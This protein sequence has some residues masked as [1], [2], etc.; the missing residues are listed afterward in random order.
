MT[1]RH[2]ETILRHCTVSFWPL[3]SR[4]SQDVLGFLGEIP[5][6]L[7]LSRDGRGVYLCNTRVASVNPEV[8]TNLFLD[9]RET[10]FFFVIFGTNLQ[11]REREKE[12]ERERREE[13]R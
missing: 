2:R 3:S 11:T 9:R 12:R 4:Q 6:L 1:V 7:C 13:K 5:G 10:L 8:F